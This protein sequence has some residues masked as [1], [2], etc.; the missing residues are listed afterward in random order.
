V[1][2]HVENIE[3]GQFKVFVHESEVYRSDREV[4]DRGFKCLGPFSEDAQGIVAMN[5]ELEGVG[6][7]PL[8]VILS[9]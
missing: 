3:N 5:K 2:I 1:R 7:D 6:V 9:W 8:S 4:D